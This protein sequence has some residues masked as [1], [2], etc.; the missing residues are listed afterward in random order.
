MGC[1]N[2]HKFIYVWG[3]TDLVDALTWSPDGKKVASASW[4]RTAQ[5][6]AIGP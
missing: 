3:H 1:K 4:D 2:W 5:I 6:W